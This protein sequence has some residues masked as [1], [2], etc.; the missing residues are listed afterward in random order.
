MVQVIWTEWKKGLANLE[1]L[2]ARYK[3]LLIEG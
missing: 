1:E 3:D 2:R